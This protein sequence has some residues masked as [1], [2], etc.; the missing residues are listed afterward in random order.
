MKKATKVTLKQ[1]VTQAAL[2][3]ENLE[4]RHTVASQSQSQAALLARLA[5]FA[6]QAATSGIMDLMVGIRNISDT[7][8]GIKSIFP[9]EPDLHLHADIGDLPDPNRVAVISNAWWQRLRRSQFMARG[10]IVR[11]DTILG[12]NYQAAPADRSEEIHPEWFNNAVM[13][14]KE[15]IDSRNEKTL[16][17]DLAKITSSESLQRLRRAVDD[18]LRI[19]EARFKAEAHVNPA[20]AAVD[21]LPA[22]YTLVDEL[23]TR[24]IEA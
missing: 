21:A 10:L 4:L 18:E 5:Q 24:R 19:L 3:A 14:P 16:R 22:L 15:W 6:P 20:Q 7:T 2:E 23:T 17:A 13:N 1:G 12:N 11:D 9:N 8:V